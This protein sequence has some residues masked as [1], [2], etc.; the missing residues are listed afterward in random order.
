MDAFPPNEVVLRDEG[1]RQRI[2]FKL[3]KHATSQY[4]HEVLTQ[5]SLILVLH[6]CRIV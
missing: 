2:T 6:R 5:F 1:N 4:D 3:E